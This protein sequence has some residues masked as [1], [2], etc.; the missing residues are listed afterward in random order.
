MPDAAARLRPASDN[1]GSG[2]YSKADYI[3]LVRYAKARGVTVIPEINMP[4]HARAAVVSMEARYKRLLAEGKEAEANQFRLTDP[5][6]TSNVTS[7][8]FYDKM[9]F[10]NPCQPGAATFVAKVMDEVAQM[11]QAAGQPLTAWHYGGDEAKNVS[12]GR[13]LSRIRPSPR[14]PIWSPGRATS[15]PASRTS[16]SASPPVPEDDRRWQDQGRGRAACPLRQGGER[17]G[18]GPR[19]LHPAGVGRWF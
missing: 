5:D 16:R 9:S 19:L 2:F 12:P 13:W 1:Q 17:D 7:V 18:Q 4:A 15:T 14:K 8:Q 6:D 10:I 11:H 3:D